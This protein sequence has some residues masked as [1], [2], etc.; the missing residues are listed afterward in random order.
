[1]TSGADFARLWTGQTI[2]AF[3]SLIGAAAMGFTAILVLHATPFQLG[4]LSA[5]RLAP[6]FLSGLVAGAWVDRMRRRPILIVADLGRAV[7]LGTIPLAAVF[8]L[9][10]M[11]QLYAVTLLVSILTIFFDVAYQS[12]LPTLVGRT[13]LI[14][15]NSKLAASASV[16]E[17]SGFGVAGWLVQ[18]FT[19]P[20]TIGIDAASFVISA[21]SIWLIRAPE[22]APVTRPMRP[23]IWREIGEGLRVTVR[24]TTLRALAACSL[25][26]D[27]FIGMYGTLVVVFMV[28]DLGFAPGILGAIWATGGVSSLAGAAATK[29]LTNRFGIGPV[30]VV[31]LIV[32][33][34]SLFF[35][36]LARGATVAA[37]VLL[38]SQQVFGDGGATISQINQMSLRQA[39]VPDRLLGRVNA[40]AEFIRVG[41]ALF[42]SLAG[43]ALGEIA[44]VRMTLF[45]SA[46]GALLSML[47]L[48]LSPIRGLKVAPLCAE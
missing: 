13:E 29:R 46:L 9:L 3:G 24:D 47:W 4:I 20:M 21:I 37:A 23:N 39:I 33:V 10:R 41:A 26:R 28:R 40:S 32:F 43:G 48:V 14:E 36:P 12:Y 5:A 35:V 45:T 19:A 15:G 44:G 31:G 34:V 16:A 17:V 1:M 38:I 25:F 7:L 11:E 22:P 27:F 8:G 18:I 30:I 6:G 42:G 2:S